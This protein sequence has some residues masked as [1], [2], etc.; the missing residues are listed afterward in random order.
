M[1]KKHNRFYLITLIDFFNKLGNFNRLG[2]RS[3]P[4]LKTRFSP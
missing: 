3:N 2:I 4:W 1:A